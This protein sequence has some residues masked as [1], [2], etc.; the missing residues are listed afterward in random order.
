MQINDR[1]S[2]LYE[3]INNNEKEKEKEKQNPYLQ[4][5]IKYDEKIL[6]IKKINGKFIFIY[7]YENIKKEKFHE[8]KIYIN[9]IV[10]NN[11]NLFP[12]IENK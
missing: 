9:K 3:S 4:N 6:L 2:T 11:E 1:G 5:K 10:M 7:N 8:Y 12:L